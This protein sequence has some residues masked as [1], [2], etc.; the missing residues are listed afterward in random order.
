MRVLSSTY[1]WRGDVEPLAGL[2]VRLRKLG[3]R[4]R[5]CAADPALGLWRKPADL[6][7]VQAGPWIDRS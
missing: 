3:A 4:V 6:H 2:A 5:V 1:G 7:V